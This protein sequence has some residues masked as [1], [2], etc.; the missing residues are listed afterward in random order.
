LLVAGCTN[1][2]PFTRVPERERPVAIVS[3]GTSALDAFVTYEAD[4][5]ASYD[6]DGVV[7]EWR[8]TIDASPEGSG[9]EILPAIDAPQSER[10]RFRPDLVGSYRVGLVVVDDDGLESE[11]A[12]WEFA[13]TD[14]SGLRLELTWDRDITDVDLHLVSEQPD[15]A[16]FAE[17]WDC[18]FQN[19]A[20]DWGIVGQTDDDPYLPADDDDGFGPE[21]IGLRAPAA[22]SYRILTHYYCDDGFGGTQATLRVFVNGTNLAESTANLVRTGDLWDVATLT[23]DASGAVAL[24]MS[25]SGVGASTHGCE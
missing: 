25:T 12:F 1:E 6:S 15:A 9:I 3:P 19:D 21:V 22:G 7:V 14:A 20:P 17:P 8:W 4:G 16:F 18:Y 10:I 13:V 2:S 24:V 23:F 5:T 11:P